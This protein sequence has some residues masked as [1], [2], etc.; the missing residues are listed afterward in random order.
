MSRTHLGINLSSSMFGKSSLSSVTAAK[1]SWNLS[2][3]L[4]G[5]PVF[6]ETCSRTVETRFST[7]TAWLSDSMDAA[8]QN[9]RMKVR[10]INM[11]SLRRSL[12]SKS[13]RKNSVKIFARFKHSFIQSF[14]I[15]FVAQTIDDITFVVLTLK[16]NH[17]RP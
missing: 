14:H 1:K 10:K 5:V 7:L 17:R 6:M 2:G 9:E 8:I 4:L 11:V 3:K 16:E 13:S 15:L 12:N